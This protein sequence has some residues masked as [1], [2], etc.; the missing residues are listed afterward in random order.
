[1]NEIT[2]EEPNSGDIEDDGTMP[3]NV[4]ELAGHVVGHRIVKAGNR[5]VDVPW[6]PGSTHYD[7]KTVLALT[8]DNG[9]QVCLADTDDCCAY[10]ELEK[11]IEH[12]PT[13]DHIITAVN[14]TDGYTRWHILAD[15]GE[16]LELQVGWSAGNPFY[17]G[18][19][20]TIS[21]VDAPEEQP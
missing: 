13:V 4:A 16:V 17:Y 3:E 5:V 11:V 9:R 21:V 10:T 1:M 7:R 14:T 15:A 19:G 8:L 20:F 6:W 2:Y 18:Y 12:L